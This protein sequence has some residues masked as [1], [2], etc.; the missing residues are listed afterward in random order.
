MGVKRP[1]TRYAAFFSFA[2]PDRPLVSR[3]HALFEELDH[4]TYFAPQNLPKAG[5]PRWRSEI[6]R[7]LEASRCFIPIY[8]R[9]ALKRP[10]VLF[11]SGMAHALELVRFP[12][13]VSNVSIRDINEEPADDDLVFDLGDRESLKDL[14]VNVC[15]LARKASRDHVERKLGPII[16]RS[17][18]AKAILR[19]ARARWVFIAGNIPRGRFRNPKMNPGYRSREY[20]ARL[21][22]FAEDLTI[23]LLD[24]GFKVASCPQVDAV[25]GVAARAASR[26]VAEH[27][28]AGQEPYQ[29]GGLHP[30]DMFVRLGKMDEPVR[31]HMR[32]FL[33]QYRKS[34]LTGKEWLVVLGGSEG[35]TEECDV[36]RELK[37]RIMAFPCFGGAGR[38]A[39]DKGARSTRQACICGKGPGNCDPRDVVKTMMT[40]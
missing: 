40:R 31:E 13:R 10:W 27:D 39:W 34:Y 15:V 19:L 25:G 38:A 2:D 9:H 12:A 17:P 5:S 1:R 7:G 4:K 36:A 32:K 14:V 8:T 21:H 11:E 30:I 33:R 24:A 20:A 26:W 3:L 18:H 37:M 16:D 28:A 6:L 35:T 23:A 29:I 22:I